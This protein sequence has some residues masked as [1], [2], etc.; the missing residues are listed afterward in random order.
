MRKGFIAAYLF[1]SI[2]GGKVEQNLE[3]GADAEVTEDAADWLP[4][5][6][7]PSLFS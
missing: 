6:D 3:A 7:L 4:P 1:I 2:R 5:Q